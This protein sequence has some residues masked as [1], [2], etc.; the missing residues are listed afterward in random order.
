MKLHPL[1]ISD[2]EILEDVFVVHN[3]EL[4]K[5]DYNTSR[6]LMRMLGTTCGLFGMTTEP[7]AIIP[8][9]NNEAKDVALI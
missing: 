1:D 6:R 7:E 9:C 8:F 2:I 3:L 4:E 5:N